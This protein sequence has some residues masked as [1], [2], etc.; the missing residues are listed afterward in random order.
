MSQAWKWLNLLVLFALELV[1]M[2]AFGIWGWHVGGGLLLRIVLAVGLPLLAAVLWGMFAAARKPRYDVPAAA[3]IV[4]LVVFGGAALALWG[5]GYRTA[6][7][8]FAVL[9][10]ANLTAIRLGRLD[11]DVD[12]GVSGPRR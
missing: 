8:V 11:A 6:A 9:L 2:I 12:L 7:I 1:A 3:L 4:K 10:V 5:S